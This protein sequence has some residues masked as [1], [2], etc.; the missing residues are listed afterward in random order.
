L[1]Q[2][3]DD[4]WAECED[5]FAQARQTL[6][7]LK[8]PQP[9][10]LVQASVNA[11]FR[12]THTLKGMAGMLG[13]MSFS[14]AAHRM[15]D[16]F[17]LM[18]KGRLRSSESLVDTLEAGV[19][20]LESGLEDL[21]RGRPEPEDY[22]HS[23]RREL[24]E[25]EA[26]AL[27]AEGEAQDLTSMLDLPQ[28]A[29]KALS[30]YER[31]RITSLLMSGMPIHGVMVCLDFATF[32]E[33]LRFLSE[34]LGAKG[35]L[36]STLPWEAPEQ[37][38]GLAFLL[39]AACPAMELDGLPL[40]EGELLG[41]AL[42]ADPTR[43][44]AAMQK[45]AP[46]PPVEAVPPP[47]VSADTVAQPT[48]AVAPLL[49]AAQ[50][51]GQQAPEVEIL[52]LPAH[53]V[54]ALEAQL[55][56][57]GQLRDTA[58]L[59]LHKSEGTGREGPL[60]L[61]AQMEDGLLEV[62]KALLQMRMVKVESL[63]SRIEPIVK[64]LSRDTGKPVKLGFA[65]GDLELERSLLGKLSEPFLHLVRNAVDHGL[66][67]PEERKA[68]G[69]SETGSLRI[70]AS[71]RGRNLRFD[72]RD[73]GR[74]F[75]LERIQARGIE[76]GLLK[77]GQVHTP[78][79]LHRLTLEPGFSTKDRASQLSGRGVGMDVVRAEIEAQGGEIHLSSE[80]RR[81]S[82]IRMSIPLSRA[83]IS[84]LKVRCAGQDF[85]IPL[86]S[87][88]RVQAG[89]ELRF[90]GDQVNVLGMSLPLESLQACLGLPEPSGQQAFVVLGQRGAAARSVAVALGVDEIL[91]RGELLLR[92]LPELA[93]AAGVMGGSAQEE[94]VLWVLDPEAML[95][96]AMDSLMRRVARV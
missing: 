51:V 87:V 89:R 48:A 22:L 66:E 45:E 78:E 63:F 93:H 96:L 62:Q 53:R 95:G 15:E 4:V 91:G 92:S 61:M 10:H 27:P 16:I 5:L 37:R 41:T 29:I 73:D 64:S 30:E 35:E 31:T 50:A 79:R 67:P 2:S 85:G 39:M 54:E 25:L 84:C 46:S 11:L 52:R 69:K 47:Q 81:G 44:L 13:F 36:I 76:L 3:F 57:V 88:M 77:P 83:V 56:A 14:R 59:L 60:A 18:R 19:L 65:G 33:R 58:S 38:E 8:E 80:A 7:V 70:S 55:M 82:L 12:T 49:A 20:A 40:E 90:G 72:I 28:E 26:L 42:L 71:Q 21:R 1:D 68:L 74:G 94:G 9:A 6:V 43:I 32:D 75:N 34:A 86:G 17:D 23:L 24:G